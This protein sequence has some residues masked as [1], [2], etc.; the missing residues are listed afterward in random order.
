MKKILVTTD[1]SECAEKALLQAKELGKPFSAK[2]VIMTVMNDIVITPYVTLQ[3]NTIQQ[4]NNDLEE[5]GKRILEESLKLFKDYEGEVE[6]K[7]ERG[8]PAD[9][10]VKEAE[11]ES[12]DLIVMGSR[13][14][15]GFSRAMMGSVSSRVLHHVKTNVLIVR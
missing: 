2:I 8:N 9:V 11:R 13:G 5:V 12:Y 7:F 10:I 14:L 15:G 3:Y 1:G 4:S 6:T